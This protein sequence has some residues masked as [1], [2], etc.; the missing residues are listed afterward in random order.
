MSTDITIPLDGK[1]S[2]ASEPHPYRVEKPTQKA[3][4][5][6]TPGKRAQQER[7][8]TLNAR[9]HIAVVGKTGAT[10]FWGTAP[11]PFVFATGYSSPPPPEP[12]IL[13]PIQRKRR[14]GRWMANHPGETPREELD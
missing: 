14:V 7:L 1:I 6:P 8:R 3:V 11:R 13:R 10:V 5:R 12:P 4:S 2:L 9:G